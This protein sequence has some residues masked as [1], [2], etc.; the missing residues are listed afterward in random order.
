MTLSTPTVTIGG[1]GATVDFAGLAPGFVG[2]Y[3]F[4]FVVPNVP[5]GDQP[6]TI[7]VGSV[8]VP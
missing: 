5:D 3:Q 4:N 2:L 1:A 7:R 6:V 8:A